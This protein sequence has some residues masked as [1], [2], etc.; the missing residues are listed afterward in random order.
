MSRCE[1][2]LKSIFSKISKLSCSIYKTAQ[3]LKKYPQT[4][5][6]YILTVFKF[7][8]IFVVT[9]RSASNLVRKPSKAAD[10]K[11]KN[12]FNNKHITVLADM[13]WVGMEG[14]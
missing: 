9:R 8:F 1:N 3:K 7:L 12:P 10:K 13:G 4:Y 14:T 6:F 11:L 2:R 5:F